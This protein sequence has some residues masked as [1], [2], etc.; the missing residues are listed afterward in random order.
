MTVR[1]TFDSNVFR[2]V[3]D[4][5]QFPKDPEKE[6]IERIHSAITK[7]KIIPFFSSS[8]G[9]LEGIRKK[10]RGDYLSGQRANIVFSEKDTEGDAIQMS[11]MIGPK[12]DEFPS[13]PEGFESWLQKA[14]DI[15]FLFLSTPR[16][17]Q[18]RPK[19]VIE[20]SVEVDT[21]PENYAD[22]FGELSRQ[23]EAK[24]VGKVVAE[25]I[26]LRIAKRDNKEISHWADCLNLPADIHEE[27]EIERAVGEWSDAD[28]IA[29][30]WAYGLEL[31]C[32]E[33]RGISA[34][35]NSVLSPQNRR[36]LRD[37][38]GIVCVTTSELAELIL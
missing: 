37:D 34:G 5:Y 21:W 29:A 4:P 9:S 19:I 12:N 33:D 16:L 11:I 25:Q 28:S 15:G 36:W 3:V 26:G 23:I 32:T 14:V 17:A 20:N 24:G 18:A 27:R 7:N 38:Y 22:K 30:H 31:F 13:L 8:I 35:G 10:A 1:V 6:N 2:R